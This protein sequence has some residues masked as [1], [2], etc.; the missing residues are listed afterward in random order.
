[1]RFGSIFT[2]TQPSAHHPARTG[3][4]LAICLSLLHRTAAQTPVTV[5]AASQVVI[6]GKA[7]IIS[8]GS[9]AEVANSFGDLF[10][11]FSLDLTVPWETSN[12]EYNLFVDGPSD[13]Y[14][15]SGLSGDGS[16]IVIS[17]GQSFS[18]NLSNPNSWTLA[19][20]LSN[21][22]TSKATRL[23]GAIDPATNTFYLPG[24]YRVTGANDTMM[25][26]SIA[27]GT[28]ASLPMHPTLS[29]YQE[30]TAAWSAYAK[31][32]FMHGGLSNNPV[33]PI[34]GDLFA[35]NPASNTWSQ[36]VT[37]GTIPSARH[38]HCMVSDATGKRLVVFGGFNATAVPGL[39]D[40]YVLDVATMQWQKGP[41]AGSDVARGAPSCG[42]DH[43]FFIVWGGGYSSKA[44]TKNVTLLFNLQTMQWVDKFV[45]AA[46]DTSTKPSSSSTGA[47]IG[48]VVGG[49]AVIAIVIGRLLYQRKQARSAPL[50]KVEVTEGLHHHPDGYVPPPSAIQQHNE[51]YHAQRSYQQQPSPETNESRQSPQHW[52]GKDARDPNSNSEYRLHSMEPIQRS[53][54]QSYTP[55]ALRTQQDSQANG[56]HALI[57]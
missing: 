33:V 44:V 11:T 12:P 50:D 43:D 42:I 17:R 23:A 28:T 22:I 51:H 47:I 29:M 1:M 57:S 27:H 26:Y 13:L 39:S 8:G 36:S 38:N 5:Y 9:P 40:I 48:G 15:P 10:Q 21:G 34:L 49:L 6:Q 14:V 19:G 52:T 18:F 46:P 37:A 2:F 56:P 53:A 55:T 31:R 32:L 16:M 35:F 3:I 30:S 20:S 45:P 25:V 24:G 54:P 7:M 41:D 4:L